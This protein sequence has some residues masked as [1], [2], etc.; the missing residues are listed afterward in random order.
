M[1]ELLEVLVIT[2]APDAALQL[3]GMTVDGSPAALE[4]NAEPDDSGGFDCSVSLVAAPVAG[5]TTGT[6]EGITVV[7]K[8]AADSIFAGSVLGLNAEGELT[9]EM[10]EETGGCGHDCSCGAGGGG[11]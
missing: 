2:I 11:C 4:F 10:M 7:F 5:A 9:P 1:S 3:R 8:G 6:I